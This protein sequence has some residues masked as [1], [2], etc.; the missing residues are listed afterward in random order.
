[1]LTLT[2]FDAIAVSQSTSYPAISLPLGA[3]SLPL[4]VCRLDLR[5]YAVFEIKGL[6]IFKPVLLIIIFL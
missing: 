2:E 3:N 6:K 4:E 5:V 1:M